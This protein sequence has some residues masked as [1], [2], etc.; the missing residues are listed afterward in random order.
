MRHSSQAVPMMLRFDELWESG[1]Y[2][3]IQAELAGDGDGESKA[4]A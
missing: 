2:Q 4:G 3:R 1:E